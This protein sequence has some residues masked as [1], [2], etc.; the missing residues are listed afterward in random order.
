M[1]FEIKQIPSQT[2]KQQGVGAEIIGLDIDGPISL[3][4]E[5]ALQQAWLDYGILLFRG[6]G[7]SPEAQ[8]NLSRCFGKQEVHP[9]ENI[10]VEGY[11]ELIWLANK[12]K[13]TTPVYNY[14]GVATVSKIP[15]HSDLVYTTT[16][17]RGA[18]FRMVTMPEQGGDT[19][20]IDTAKAYVALPEQT[21]KKIDSLEAL[22]QFI[23]DPS[24]MRFGKHNVKR[25]DTDKTTEGNFYP[26]FPDIAHPIVWTHPISARKSLNLSTLHLREIIDM[27][28]AEGD[29]LLDELVAH[30][31]RPEFSYV[32]H[33]QENDMILWDNWRTMHAAIGHPPQFKRL[34]HRTTI[35][36][37]HVFGRVL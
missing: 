23:I 18:L 14:D 12:D 5:Q 15:W 33:W 1:S 26:D 28:K 30:V 11:P 21:K 25:D 8:L 13:A 17:S 36:G 24:E 20:W 19:G 22:F 27:D 16:P 31:T 2:G 7:T 6:I 34:A 37:E 32:H 3:A 9:I 10:R 29:A 4:T 35:K